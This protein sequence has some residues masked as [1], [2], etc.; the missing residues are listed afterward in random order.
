MRFQICIIISV[1]KHIFVSTFIFHLTLSRFITKLNLN[2]FDW[3]I[4]FD[5]VSVD[6]CM[7]K[8]KIV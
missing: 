5:F 3:Q 7:C 1:T 8:K 4:I 6:V 2:Y